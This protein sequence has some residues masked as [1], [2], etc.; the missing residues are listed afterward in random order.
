M[1]REQNYLLANV[2]NL[3]HEIVEKLK[4]CPKCDT[5][6][7]RFLCEALAII[8]D[9]EIAAFLFLYQLSLYPEQ[10]RYLYLP[11]SYN[12]NTTINQTIILAILFLTSIVS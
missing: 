10:P 1:N 7:V 11:L 3:R 2:W 5:A 9:F 4:T 8:D 12:K 6:V